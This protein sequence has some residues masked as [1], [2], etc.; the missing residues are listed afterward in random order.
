MLSIFL[1]RSIQTNWLG[2][3][4][5]ASLAVILAD[6]WQWT[7]IMF[8]FL[9]S[10]LLTLSKEPFSAAT[11]LGASRIQ[12]FRYVTMPSLKPFIL[13]AILLRSIELF[14]LFDVP[15]TMTRGGPGR[16]TETIS[17]FMFYQGFKA[18]KLAYVSAGAV[19][20]LIPFLMFLA[21]VGRSVVRFE[22]RMV[23]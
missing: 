5:L 1:G 7:P 18:W 23:K 9:Y 13:I 20:I 12:I 21:L 22:G 3:P 8:I 11:V 2:H 6:V 17:I 16:A 10:G 19:I 14:K 15:F 4:L